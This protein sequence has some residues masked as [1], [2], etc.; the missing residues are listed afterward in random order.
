MT[1]IKF[2][3]ISK[4]GFE[5]NHKD[6]LIDWLILFNSYIQIFIILFLFGC[7]VCIA[8]KWWRAKSKLMSLVQLSWETNWYFICIFSFAVIMRADDVRHNRFLMRLMSRNPENLALGILNGHNCLVA[9]TYKYSLGEY[10]SAFKQVHTTTIKNC[11]CAN[12]IKSDQ[13]VSFSVKDKDWMYL[14]WIENKTINMRLGEKRSSWFNCKFSLQVIIYKK[15]LSLIIISNEI[16]R[17]NSFKF[18]K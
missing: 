7:I 16:Q 3:C 10:M 12:Q 8:M 2:T 4:D 18:C 15:V 9:G 17:K 11:L 5:F 1:T 6:W 13:W 14:T